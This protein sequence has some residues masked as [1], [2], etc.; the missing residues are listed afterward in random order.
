MSESEM[1]INPDREHSMGRNVS[2]DQGMEGMEAFLEEH[3]LEEIASLMKTFTGTAKKSAK[4]DETE[5]SE[6]T[7]EAEKE[8]K[9]REGQGATV[10]ESQQSQGAQARA[11]ARAVVEHLSNPG[12]PGRPNLPRD[13]G[14]DPRSIPTDITGT[15]NPWLAGSRLTELFLAFF[16]LA[17]ILMQIK[18]Q[19][20]KT[21]VESMMQQMEMAI[22]SAEQ[23]FKAKKLEAEKLVLDAIEKFVSA[24]ISIGMLTLIVA[25]ELKNQ[26]GDMNQMSKGPE[27]AGPDGAPDA[28]RLPHRQTL[29][30]RKPKQQAWMMPKVIN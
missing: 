18:I 4:S 22:A 27:G 2:G 26:A 7:K 21:Q 5:E 19:E 10:A 14:G 3:E 12:S 24:A 13:N 20:V 29:P 11:T 25:N 6:E 28:P 16:N 17:P 23:A 30:D 1:P 9:A 8:T 15:G